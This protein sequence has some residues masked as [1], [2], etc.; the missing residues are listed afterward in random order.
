M[1]EGGRSILERETQVWTDLI[2]RHSAGEAGSVLIK[3]AR[4]F[5][6]SS[7]VH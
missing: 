5:I 4:C 1:S 3:E 2:N 7:A 6:I